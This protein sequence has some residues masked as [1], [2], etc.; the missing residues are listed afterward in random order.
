MIYKRTDF[1]RKLEIMNIYNGQFRGNILVVG[2]TGSG[3]TYFLQKLD[4]H[5]FFWEIVK[6]EWISGIKISKTE[7][8]QWGSIL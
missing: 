4:L 2:K 7:K 5:N 6:A 1:K 8:Q 3:K